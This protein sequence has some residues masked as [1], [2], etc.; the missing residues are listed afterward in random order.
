M[1][2]ICKRII[3][4]SI[5]FVL[6]TMLI[7]C[8]G[9][10]TGGDVA[11]NPPLASAPASAAPEAE[12]CSHMQVKPEAAPTYEIDDPYKT[13]EKVISVADTDVNTSSMYSGFIIQHLTADFKAMLPAILNAYPEWLTAAYGNFNSDT[14]CLTIKGFVPTESGVQRGAYLTAYRY[15]YLSKGNLFIFKDNRKTTEN[16]L[17]GVKAPD[18]AMNAAKDIAESRLQEARIEPGAIHTGISDWRVTGLAL[19]PPGNEA[20]YGELDITE[21]IE[22]YK[23]TCQLQFNASSIYSSD[24]YEI[25]EDGWGGGAYPHEFFLVFDCSGDNPVLLGKQP[26]HNAVYSDY[27]VERTL[28]E[29]GKMTLN[30]FTSYYMLTLLANDIKWFVQKLSDLPLGEQK[31]VCSKVVEG[32]NESGSSWIAFNNL[33]TSRLTLTDSI[34][35]GL[36]QKETDSWLLLKEY[37][38]AAQA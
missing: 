18:Y 16:V 25:D 32:G 24:F 36:S 30:D 13:L 1:N 23:L 28:V 27:A 6:L 10:G 17:E 5:L 37:C 11:D 4:L 3:S 12:D 35:A 20:A 14:A 38:D 19:Y 15:A 26:A 31:E 33:R 2:Y 8:A 7:S 21:N 22:V 34:R 9:N 29:C